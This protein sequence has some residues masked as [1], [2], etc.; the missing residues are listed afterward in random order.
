ET[1]KESRSM[2]APSFGEGLVQHTIRAPSLLA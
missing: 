1:K 2:A